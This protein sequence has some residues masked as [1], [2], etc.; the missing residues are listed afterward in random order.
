T[1]TVTVQDLSTACISS[2]TAVNIPA[3][4]ASPAV[5]TI[6]TAPASCASS[7]SATITNY[8]GTQTYTFTPVGPTVGI[9]GTITGM[10]A[11]TSY[12]VTTSNGSC[13]SAASISFSVA[14][15][16]TTP[17]V[18][19]VSTTA[20]TCLTDG[21]AAIT[22]FDGSVTYTFSP[23]G[24]TIGAGGVINGM[25]FGTN[26]TLTASNGVCTSSSSTSFSI[27]EQLTTP[28][29]PTIITTAAS[30]TTPG[31]ATISNYL[32]TLTYTFSPSGPTVGVGGVIS[33]MVPGTSYSVT[34]DNGSCFSGVSTL[35][36]IEAE[37]GSPVITVSQDTSFS[38][39]ESITLTASGAT[40]YTWSP[41]TD[42]NVSSGPTVVATP[43]MTTLYCVVGSDNNGCTDTACV[44]L[45]LV[46]DCGN[47]FIP[48]VFSP[49]ENNMDDEL[50]IFGWECLNDV[51][52][53]IYNRWGELIFETTDPSICWDGKFREEYVS[54]GAFAY[55]FE[56]TDMNGEII[57]REGTIT[58]L[59]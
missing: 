54:S 42:L 36:S 37:L 30:C 18:P 1:V 47:V 7:G 35:F 58:V 9:G 3:V 16:L 43:E 50:C 57:K 38:L 10:T 2:G 55:T 59:K 4:P 51:V 25:A 21:T 6:V 49:N 40:S 24:P 28:N 52:F 19:T 31:L 29:D 5:P 46:I 17:V 53:R 27:S 13:S 23:T 26:Y 39:G 15:Q 22:N 32:G 44:L 14:A 48:N 20:A 34:A 33:G 41:A 8:V 11:G 56:G 12:T 45:T